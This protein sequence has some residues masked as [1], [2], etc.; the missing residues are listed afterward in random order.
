MD[1]VN[2]I[3]ISYSLDSADT[4]CIVDSTKVSDGTNYHDEFVHDGF[5]DVISELHTVEDEH[6]LD[7]DLP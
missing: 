7:F 1:R 4:T 5:P 2:R 3:E 6:G